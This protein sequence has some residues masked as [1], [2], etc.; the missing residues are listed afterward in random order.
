[1]TICNLLRTDPMTRVNDSFVLDDL[2]DA[3]PVISPKKSSIVQS[4]P[5]SIETFYQ[6]NFYQKIACDLVVE[7]VFDYPYPCVTEKLL[8][9]IACK[10]MFIVMGPHGILKLLVSKG[11][12]TFDDIIDESYDEIKNPSDR[13]RKVI[14]EARK[15]CDRPLS[16]I[17]QYLKNNQYRL[18][19]NFRVLM[20]L[21]QQELQN[22]KSQLDDIN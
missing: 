17:V 19:K 8:R 15:F 14:S 18:E 3:S 6:A 5:N 13:F 21:Q 22:L 11:F 20:N 7:T 12:V 10:R 16:E 9:P 1:M 4:A 2:I